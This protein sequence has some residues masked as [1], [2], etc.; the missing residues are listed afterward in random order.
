MEKSQIA[1]KVQEIAAA[2]LGRSITPSDVR[3]F[4]ILN[5][6][7]NFRNVASNDY[8]DEELEEILVEM[9]R[10]GHISYDRLNNDVKIKRGFYDFMVEVLSGS[11]DEYKVR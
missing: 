1:A 11:P 4:S 9:D 2:K 6:A 8:F 10:G 5:K 7:S 3:L